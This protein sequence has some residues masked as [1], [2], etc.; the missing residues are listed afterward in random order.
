QG[1]PPG[2]R[3]PDAGAC[4]VMD[5]SSVSL[6]GALV[7]G[8][9]SF[10]SPCVL[11]IVPGYLS[12]ISGVNVMQLKGGAPA[13]LARRIGIT[14]IVFVLGFST[15]FVTLGAAAT[16]VGYLLQQYK[17]EFGLVGGVLVIVLG[18]HMTGIFRIKW[19][20]YEAR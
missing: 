5:G 1:R 19:L 15:V 14:S 10:V 8:L 7:A 11:P 17:R 3:Q 6:G 12:F 20:L 16:Y 18:L 2:L 9:A 4:A 13:H